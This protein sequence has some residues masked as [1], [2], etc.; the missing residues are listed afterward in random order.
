M[1]NLLCKEGII[2]LLV[3]CMLVTLLIGTFTYFSLQHGTLPDTYHDNS[4]VPFG[5]SLLIISTLLGISAA[6]YATYV[7]VN[8]RK[9]KATL[10]GSI[11]LYTRKFILDDAKP[12]DKTDEAS[13]LQYLANSINSSI[14]FIKQIS[15]GNLSAKL[16]SIQPENLPLNTDTLTGRLVQMRDQLKFVAEEENKKYRAAE[17]TMLFTTMLRK[18]HDNVQAFCFNIISQLIHHLKASQGGIYLI[19]ETSSAQEACMELKACYAYSRKRFSH[20]RIHAGEGP[21]GQAW[22]EK[23]T[24]YFSAIPP[25][26]NEAIYGVTSKVLESILVV[27]L[28]I[29]KQVIGIIEIASAQPMQLHERE[30]VQTLA[31]TIARTILTVRQNENT[32]MLLQATQA[33]TEQ[34][35][36]QEEEMRHNLHEIMV[37]HEKLQR[38]HYEVIH[39]QENLDKDPQI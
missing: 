13:V 16:E 37:T 6:L 33:M 8:E 10:L 17:Q 27:P 24:L 20:L 2:Y 19:S 31:D 38:L 30:Y 25:H 5:L 18:H 36:A 3:A 39:I 1:K 23:K 4:F 9:A 11:Y 26:Y 7:V 12:I 15:Q 32:R 35:K 21:V 29:D 34:L 28:L 22:E 14:N